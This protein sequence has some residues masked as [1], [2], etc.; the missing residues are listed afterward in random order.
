[1]LKLA[2]VLLY[3]RLDRAHA[4][5]AFTVHDELVIES[6]AEYADVAQRIMKECMTDAARRFLPR[7]W[8]AVARELEPAISTKYDK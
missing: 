6:R 3:E 1:M 8:V 4:W 5:I 2:M 7:L